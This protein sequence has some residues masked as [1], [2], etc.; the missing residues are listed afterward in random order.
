MNSDVVLEGFLIKRGGRP[1]Y[2]WLKRYFKL[3]KDKCLRYYGKKDD[4]SPKGTIDLMDAVV[5]SSTRKAHCFAISIPSGRTYYITAS[6][7]EEKQKWF[8][9]L[10]KMTTEKTTEFSIKR[11]R[12]TITI[13]DIQIDKKEITD[14]KTHQSK[15]TRMEQLQKQFS[16]HHKAKRLSDAVWSAEEMDELLHLFEQYRGCDSCFSVISAFF[17][18][19]NKTPYCIAQKLLI[20][21]LITEDEVREIE[22][23]LVDIVPEE[24]YV[25]ALNNDLIE[26]EENEEDVP[27]LFRHMPLRAY[28]NIISDQPVH[29]IDDSMIEMDHE[30]RKLSVSSIQE[31]P[32]TAEEIAEMKVN[33]GFPL[34][35]Q[36]KQLY[37]AE[38]VRKYELQQRELSQSR[39]K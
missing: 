6:T 1:T 19:V 38:M 13:M 37:K 7:E 18:D 2:N 11:R 23:E 8:D 22:P 14:E 20:L 29:K 31:M 24:T 5:L 32:Q 36:D 28:V 35:D 26:K 33:M 3:T 10:Q 4:S 21:E 9:E 15:G 17:E 30:S 34:T 16:Q 12:T 27:K 25:F 39:N